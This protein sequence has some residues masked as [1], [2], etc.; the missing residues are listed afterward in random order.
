MPAT[1][2]I[3]RRPSPTLLM[4]RSAGPGSRPFFRTVTDMPMMSARRTP[5][6]PWTTRTSCNGS[7]FQER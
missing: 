7:T 6:V 3:M 4:I 2:V 1:W 5:R